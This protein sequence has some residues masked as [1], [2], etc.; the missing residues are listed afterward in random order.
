MSSEC[1]SMQA[2]IRKT[3]AAGESPH[4]HAFSTNS[5]LHLEKCLDCRQGE[6]VRREWACAEAEPEPGVVAAARSI[7]SAVKDENPKPLKKERVMTEPK[8]DP[9]PSGKDAAP[10]EKRCS[11]C[12]G[13]KLLEEFAFEKNGK[14][15]RK[16]WCRECTSDY[17]KSRKKGSSKKSSPAATQKR[18]DK[19]DARKDDM[20]SVLRKAALGQAIVDMAAVASGNQSDHPAPGDAVDCAYW[21]MILT[22]L[23]LGY[24]RMERFSGQKFGA[25]E[26]V[27][28]RTGLDGSVGGA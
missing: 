15:G 27:I 10:K 5:R 14:Y 21:S 25:P 8:I 19:N 12:G 11:K 1:V 20:E 16:S 7:L 22:V 28:V 9:A 4:R 3:L 13:T 17:N 2:R 6:S 26:L 23:D 24:E 18:P